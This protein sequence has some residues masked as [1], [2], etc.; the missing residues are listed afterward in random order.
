MNLLFL[1]FL[2]H[3]GDVA[4]QPSWLIANKKIHPFAIYEHAFVWSGVISVGLFMIGDFS[5]WKFFFLLIVHW[6]IDY[7]KYQKLP[8]NYYWIYPDQLAHYI[9]ILIVYFL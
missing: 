5:M 2:H 7:V 8:D 3:L 6:L 4:F 1:L 9:Q